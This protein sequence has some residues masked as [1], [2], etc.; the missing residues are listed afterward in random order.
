MH[1]KDFRKY[2][3]LLWGHTGSTAYRQNI[4]LSFT[5]LVIYIVQDK[6]LSNDFFWS[7]DI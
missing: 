7:F 6:L 1:T 5:L 3:P 4:H 2:H